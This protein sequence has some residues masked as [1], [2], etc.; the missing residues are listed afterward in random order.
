MKIFEKSSKLDHVAYDIRGPVLEEAE[1]MMA[2]GEKILRLNTGNPAAFGF[3][4]PDEVIRDLIVNARASEGYSDS[5]GIFSAR[6]YGSMSW[7]KMAQSAEI[8]SAVGC[9]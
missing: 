3:E 5:R 8:A 4:A 9:A 6:R 7:S 1:R 2:N